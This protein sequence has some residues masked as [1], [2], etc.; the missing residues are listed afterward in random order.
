MPGWR[1]T[2]AEPFG[3]TVRLHVEMER[4]IVENPNFAGLVLPFGFWYGPGTSF[5]GDGYT[6]REVRRRRY[7]IVGDGA[8]V[9]S[10]VHVDDVVSATMAS[11]NRGD[12]DVYNVCDDEPARMRD[13]LPVY[14][15]ALGAPR[16]RRVPAWLARIVAGKFLV[17]Q[18]TQMRGASNLKA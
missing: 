15:D 1:L 6:A 5:S 16:P 11:L 14:A 8:G 9:F 13:W 12:P 18:A 10:F 7:P 4:R 2:P 17:A 3:S